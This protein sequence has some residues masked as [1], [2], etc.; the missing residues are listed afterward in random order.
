MVFIQNDLSIRFYDF[1]RFRAAILS[2]Q[3]GAEARVTYIRFLFWG[4]VH[5]DRRPLEWKKSVGNVDDAKPERKKG[6]FR[7]IGDQRP[8]K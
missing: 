2:F 8:G 7:A 5:A 3:M 1:A 4:K 6:V